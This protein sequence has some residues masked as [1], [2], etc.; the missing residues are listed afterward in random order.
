MT[1]L[2]LQ[3]AVRDL[4]NEARRVC[5]QGDDEQVIFNLA[6]RELDRIATDLALR[7]NLED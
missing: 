2:E 1:K 7:S 4:A 3:N 6:G 5:K